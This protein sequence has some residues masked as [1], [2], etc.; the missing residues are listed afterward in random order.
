MLLAEPLSRLVLVL[1]G[2]IYRVLKEINQSGT[3]ILLVEQNAS[4]ALRVAHR[5]YVLETGTIILTGSGQELMGNPR[6]KNA[7]LGE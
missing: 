5:G 6:D 2:D 4:M 3:T 1:V 7:Y